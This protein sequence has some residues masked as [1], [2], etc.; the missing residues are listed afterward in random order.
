MTILTPTLSVAIGLIHEQGLLLAGQRR[1]DAPHPLAWEF[2]GGKIETGETA[3]QA[4][5]R[6]LHEELGID[7]RIGVLLHRTASR[8]PDGS[9]L[10]L[11]YYHVAAYTG[12][13][14]KLAFRYICWLTPQQ[15]A[16]YGFLHTAAN[17]IHRINQG[18]IVVPE[19]AH[20]P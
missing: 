15:S 20:L 18:D 17:L 7:A 10:S 1:H 11:A 5:Q 14:E 13:P 6:E 3:S 16:H 4:L 19:T 12:Q 2:P 8:S 9:P